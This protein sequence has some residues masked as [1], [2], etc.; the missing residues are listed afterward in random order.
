MPWQEIVAG[1]V[2]FAAGAYIAW[3]FRGRKESSGG[4]DVP[5]AR[6]IR[7]RSKRDSCGH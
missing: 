4:P 1:S 7:K 6:L 3:R 5:V 2:V